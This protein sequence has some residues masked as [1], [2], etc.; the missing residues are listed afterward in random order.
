M[1]LVAFSCCWIQRDSWSNFHLIAALYCK[2]ALILSPL[3]HRPGS[4]LLRGATTVAQPV[5]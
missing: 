5:S 4:E 2:A 1:Y 3:L